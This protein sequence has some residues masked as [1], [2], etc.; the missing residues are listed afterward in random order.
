MRNPIILAFTLAF[1]LSALMVSATPKKEK[2]SKEKAVVEESMRPSEPIILST[3][4]DTLSYVAGAALTDGLFPYLLQVGVDTTYMDDFVK[5]FYEVINNGDNPSKTAYYAG[6]DI[7][8]K[9]RDNMINAMNNDLKGGQ[10]SILDNVAYRA[11]VDVLYND[12]T[13]YT[14]KQAQKEFR[15]RFEAAK[16]ARAEY[17]Y[18]ENR[19]AG[20]A[21]LEAN[22]SNEGVVVLPSGLQ[23]KIITQGDGET[24][25]RTDKVMVN[26]EGR[27]VDGTVFDSSKQHGDKP[28]T[29]SANQV[30]KGWTEALCLMPVGSHWELYIPYDLAYGEKEQGQILPFSALVFD[31]ELVGIDKT[32]KTNTNKKK[33]EGNSATKNR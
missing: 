18:G 29:F 28:S 22:K 26:Y 12:T 23:Y 3:G 24:P 17:L 11:F 33:A 32:K 5:G 9:L 1:S 30:I 16:Q 19:R 20:E 2:K 7:A 27:L 6:M 15:E 25:K 13:H 14:V 8:K 4:A 10:D 31:V 21:F